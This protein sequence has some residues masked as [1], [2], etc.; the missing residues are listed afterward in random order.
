[1]PDVRPEIAAGM[2]TDK[3]RFSFGGSQRHGPFANANGN[4]AQKFFRGSHG[5][6]NHHDAQRDAASQRRIMVHG[7]DYQRISHNADDDGRHAI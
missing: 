2:T 7:P 6:G 3:N 5:N 4:G 1:M